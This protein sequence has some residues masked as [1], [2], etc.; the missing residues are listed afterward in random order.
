MDAQASPR[1]MQS[2]RGAG[3]PSSHPAHDPEGVFAFPS[4]GPA[5]FLSWQLHKRL[6][7]QNR[8]EPTVR[9]GTKPLVLQRQAAIP[10]HWGHFLTPS[11]PGLNK[12]PL[13][14]HPHQHR[15]GL[16]VFSQGQTRGG[17]HCCE[18]ARI[19]SHGGSISSAPAH[20]SPSFHVPAH[21]G[22]CYTPFKMKNALGSSP[23]H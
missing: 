9:T 12:I 23:W 22:L 5:Q 11:T 6:G 8:A 3:P 7:D 2:H 10:T 4:T 20:N 13:H 17:F 21:L 18:P 1:T 19:R 15:D 16:K 14:S